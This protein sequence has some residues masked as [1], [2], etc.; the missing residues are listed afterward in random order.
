MKSLLESVVEYNSIIIVFVSFTDI[1]Y[2][3]DGSNCFTMD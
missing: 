3:G 2:I 1:I